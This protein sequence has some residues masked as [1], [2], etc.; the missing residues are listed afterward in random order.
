LIDGRSQTAKSGFVDD[1]EP[2]ISG[3]ISHSVPGSINT[4]PSS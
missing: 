1:P 4:S 3:C 2:A